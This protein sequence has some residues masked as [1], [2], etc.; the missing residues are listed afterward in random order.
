[1]DGDGVSRALDQ[2]VVPLRRVKAGFG[3]EREGE[4]GIGRGRKDQVERGVVEPFDACIST[5][6]YPPIAPDDDGIARPDRTSRYGLVYS[7]EGIPITLAPTLVTQLNTLLVDRCLMRSLRT[8]RAAGRIGE[9]DP[10]EA[11]TSHSVGSC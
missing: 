8:N 5:E 3:E 4:E 11:A 7:K 9:E 10:A 6:S 2:G 1:M